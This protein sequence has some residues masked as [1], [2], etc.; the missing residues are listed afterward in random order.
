MSHEGVPQER[1]ELA[2]IG[3]R[4]KAES[5]GLSLFYAL[6]AFWTG[7]GTNLALRSS[8]LTV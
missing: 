8:V 7:G 2:P 4:S 3:L 6:G 5:L 1:S